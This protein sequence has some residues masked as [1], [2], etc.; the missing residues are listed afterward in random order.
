M[1]KSGE[2][3]WRDLFQKMAQVM[4]EVCASR[5]VMADAEAHRIVANLA[6]AAGLDD[7]NYELRLLADRLAELSGVSGTGRGPGRL[8]VSSNTLVEQEKLQQAPIGGRL[9]LRL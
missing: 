4:R 8:G 7:L 3:Q 2:A 6:R 5:K 1:V 9:H